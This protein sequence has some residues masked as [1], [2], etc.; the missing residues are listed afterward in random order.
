MPLHFQ[1]PL[2]L[3]TARIASLNVPGTVAIETLQR[4]ALLEGLE[5]SLLQ[6]GE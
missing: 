4:R 5:C 1:P 3:A 6:E 2:T